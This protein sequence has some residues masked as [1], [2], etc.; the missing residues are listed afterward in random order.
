MAQPISTPSAAAVLA[1][2][3][4]AKQA[5]V[6]KVM[7]TALI[8]YLY[9]LDLYMAEETQG[10]TWTGAAWR[11][12]HFG[13]FAAALA[14][15]LDQLA[16]QSLIQEALGGGQTKDY[17]LYSVGEWSLAKTFEELGIPRDVRMRLAQAIRHFSNELSA[18]LDM[19][20]FHTEPMRA[21]VPG[22][23]LSFQNARK[24]NFK[25]DI[26]PIKILVTD[27][28]KA[29][30]IRELAKAIGTE[31]S[32]ASKGIPPSFRPPIRDEHFAL[33][34]NGTEDEP[35]TGQYSAELSFRE[36]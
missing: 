27:T 31:Y 20:Y 32:Q 4:E 23:V 26:K 14:E 29:A 28:K 19:V 25:A 36:G 3:L 21:A 5:G 13:P 8:K 33:A 9:L 17:V 7:R 34:T 12:S 11:F 16:A 24:I 6:G 22:Q 1:I 30:R 35:I 18:L 2:L 10:T 15:E